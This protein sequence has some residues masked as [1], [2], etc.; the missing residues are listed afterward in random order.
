M[1]N[2]MK[3]CSCLQCRAGLR[4]GTQSR[5]VGMLIRKNRRCVEV[6]LKA[7]QGPAASFSIGR[8]D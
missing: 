5:L 6:K 2:H 4:T 7:G 3:D 8:T 1:G